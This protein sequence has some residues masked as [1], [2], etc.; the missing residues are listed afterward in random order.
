ML[1]S[2]QRKQQ[3]KIGGNVPE[4]EEH[5]MESGRE[6]RKEKN[7][8]EDMNQNIRKDQE[9]GGEKILV[10]EEQRK[11]YHVA[12]YTTSIKYIYFYIE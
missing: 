1:I 10:N 9:S 2:F 3:F 7:S 8:L 11:R 5:R 6:L 12:Q 4:N